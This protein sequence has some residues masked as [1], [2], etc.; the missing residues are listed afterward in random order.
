MSFYFGEKNDEDEDYKQAIVHVSI[1]HDFKVLK[2]DV[3]LMG[4]PDKAYLSSEVVV[5]FH[6]PG[7]DNNE[8][9]Y[10]DSNGLE[11]Q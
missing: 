7:I 10:T 5:D 11:M 2:F 6:A 8:T 9:F 3:D 1:D 4:L